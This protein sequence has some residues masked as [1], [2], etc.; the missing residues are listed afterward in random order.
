M[1]VAPAS[2]DGRPP[3][4]CDYGYQTHVGARTFINFGLVALDVARIDIGDDVQVGQRCSRSQRHIRGTGGGRA[5]WESAAPI[6]IQDNVWLGGGV[7]VCPGVTV[8]QDTAVAAGSVVTRD[9]PP[10][11]LAVG[12]PARVVRSLDR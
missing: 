5:K 10:A 9:L 2:V 12:T 7:V 8:G 3:F 6:T 11:V 4:Y 1:F